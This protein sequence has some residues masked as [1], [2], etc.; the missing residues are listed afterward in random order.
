MRR[1]P[2]MITTSSPNSSSI[3]RAPTHLRGRRIGRTRSS[4]TLRTSNNAS[5]V[6]SIANLSRSTYRTRA[7]R[8]QQ[9][10]EPEP[11]DDDDDEEPMSPIASDSSDSTVYEGQISSGSSS[12]DSQSSDYSDWVGDAEQ[13]TTLEPPKRSKRKL[14]KPRA[15][16]PSEAHGS[17]GPTNGRAMAGRR[18]L[19]LGE[20]GEIPEIYR[21]P[22]WLSEVKHSLNYEQTEKLV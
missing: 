9:E 5:N 19:P 18:N 4:N 7:V 2:I 12:S 3:P 11:E 14:V 13:S 21:P 1:R 16:S 15:Y 8:D 6:Q 20:N 10:R 17:Q 22:E